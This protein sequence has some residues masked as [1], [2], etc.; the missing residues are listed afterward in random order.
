M[1]SNPRNSCHNL[2]EEENRMLINRES[3]VERVSPEST[4]SSSDEEENG[5]HV[6]I[7]DAGLGENGDAGLGENGDAGCSYS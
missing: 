5:I 7:D 6:I 4:G 2:I 3:V 1:V